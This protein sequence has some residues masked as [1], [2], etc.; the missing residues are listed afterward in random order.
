MAAYIG[1]VLV[2]VFML[3]CSEVKRLIG[4]INCK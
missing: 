3:H 2:G 4:E 1:S